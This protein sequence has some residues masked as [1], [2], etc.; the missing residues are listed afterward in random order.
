MD[1]PHDT[2]HGGESNLY[3]MDYSFSDGNILISEINPFL[4]TSQLNISLE[5]PIT[6]S[7]LPVPDNTR[8]MNLPTGQIKLQKFSGYPTE[9]PERFLSDFCAYCTF[10]DDDPRKLAAFQLHLEGPA[11]YGLPAWKMTANRRGSI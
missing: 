6:S 2:F 9:D 11:R 8:D 5:L 7:Q 10:N 1:N 3:V 4:S